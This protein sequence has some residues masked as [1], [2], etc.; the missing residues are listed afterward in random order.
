[1]KSNVKKPKPGNVNHDDFQYVSVWFVPHTSWGQL[2]DQLTGLENRLAI[3]SRVQYVEQLSSKMSQI[4]CSKDPWKMICGRTDCF[5]CISGKPGQCHVQN[6]LYYIQCLYCQEEGKVTVYI[7]KSGRTAIDRGQNHLQVLKNKDDTTPLVSH[8]LE[9]H[10]GQEWAFKMAVIKTFESPLHRQATEGFHISQYKG[11][12]LLNKKGEWGNNLPPRLIIED[13][14][15][16]SQKNPSRSSVSPPTIKSK[17]KNPPAQPKKK[18]KLMDPPHSSE[19]QPG[20]IPDKNP[21]SSKGQEPPMSPKVKKKSKLLGASAG[22]NPKLAGQRALV[23]N[24]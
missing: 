23:F 5:P 18:V 16:C 15:D 17:T 10:Q 6:V 9:N 21:E 8:W 3:K 14:Q 22:P 4:L 13:D 2:K 20:T 19:V 24:K 11:D 1:M 12:I 7:G